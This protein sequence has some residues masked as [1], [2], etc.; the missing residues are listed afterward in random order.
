V[1]E[2]L[3]FAMFV[4]LFQN[5]RVMSD[6]LHHSSAWSN[7][8]APLE[9]IVLPA[10]SPV[11]PA[12]APPFFTSPAPKT[13]AET[14]NVFGSHDPWADVQATPT[15]RCMCPSTRHAS[16]APMPFVPKPLDSAYHWNNQKYATLEDV[17]IAS[18]CT[19][20]ILDNLSQWLNVV[21]RE[22]T[23]C[24]VVVS[25][26]AL[27]DCI[28]A[29]DACIAKLANKFKMVI[30]GRFDSITEHL[31]LVQNMSENS[32]QALH[33][34]VDHL[35]KC[36]DEHTKDMDTIDN[37]V[38]KLHRNLKAFTQDNLAM[39]SELANTRAQLQH[40]H[41]VIAKLQNKLKTA[42]VELYSG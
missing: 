20:G 8:Y 35:A 11:T 41:T 32:V 16:C 17:V 36:V 42:K 28:Q 38:R 9:E 13:E 25:Y 40:A 4:Q 18:G 27:G 5:T 10:P 3:L 12:P 7:R 21:I 2:F 26:N 30:Y 1:A 33:D 39:R 24:N 6:L 23:H 14:A 19:F 31:G 34:C 29:M 37:N 22:F 15:P